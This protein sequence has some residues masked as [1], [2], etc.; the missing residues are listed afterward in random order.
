MNRSERSPARCIP[1]TRCLKASAGCT[2]PNADRSGEE[3]APWQNCASHHS[4]GFAWRKRT[5]REG[6]GCYLS[7]KTSPFFPTFIVSP[8][9][10]SHT[11]FLDDFFW[12]SFPYTEAEATPV[13]RACGESSPL[14]KETSCVLK[15]AHASS[16]VCQTLVVCEKG[17]EP[18]VTAQ[19]GCSRLVQYSGQSFEPAGCHQHYQRRNCQRRETYEFLCA[20]FSGH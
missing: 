8:P 16:G 6:S 9:V 1:Q 20:W 2:H 7:A 10:Y 15:S 12:G 17:A 5:Q 3:T 18:A 13:L 14:S 11:A 19:W 4:C